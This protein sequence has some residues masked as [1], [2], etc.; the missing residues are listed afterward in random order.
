VRVNLV[1]VRASLLAVA[2]AFASCAASP[3]PLGRS[4]RVDPPP[5]DPTTPSDLDRD[6]IPDAVDMCPQAA[7]D[8]DGFEDEDGCPDPDNDRDRIPDASDKC[9][10]DPETYNGVEDTDGCPDKGRVIRFICRLTIVDK[11][12]F[13]RN[14]SALSTPANALLDQL[15]KTV[16]GNP[17]IPWVEVQGY[18]AS[19]ERDPQRLAHA[20]AAAV[21]EYFV[22]HGV[23][24]ERLRL[25]VY[26]SDRPAVAA[27]PRAVLAS[28]RRVEFSIGQPP[29]GTPAAPP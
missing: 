18:A 29:P 15:V 24:P 25:A 1:L 23:Q 16:N 4:S 13:A 22:A 3:K 9:P 2:V 7:E 20:R 14:S 28:S 6:G 26:G 5:G 8:R 27:D 17:Q 21:M 11:V 12:Q 19:D 10:N